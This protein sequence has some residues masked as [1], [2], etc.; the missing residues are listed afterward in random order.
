MKYLKTFKSLCESN[1][2]TGGYEWDPNHVIQVLENPE[3]AEFPFIKMVDQKTADYNSITFKNFLVGLRNSLK[4]ISKIHFVKLLRYLTRMENPGFACWCLKSF[5]YVFEIDDRELFRLMIIFEDKF[6]NEPYMRVQTMEIKKERGIVD[7]DETEEDLREEVEEI[8][9][10][11]KKNEILTG[12][13]LEDAINNALDRRDFEEVS[14]L[15]KMMKESSYYD[16]E[17]ETGIENAFND[18]LL[19]IL[20]S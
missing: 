4:E 12:R 1:H 10:G 14:R 2:I 7:P 20:L 8:E 16:I 3:T 6:F 9:T 5:I 19:L 18:Y 11:R 15:S 13:D 17:D